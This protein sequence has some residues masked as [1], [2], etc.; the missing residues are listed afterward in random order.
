MNH[1]ITCQCELC[2]DTTWTGSLEEA[3]YAFISANTNNSEPDYE[4]RDPE[5]IDENP[6]HGY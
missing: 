5:I 1:D 3:E 4:P 6:E 2:R